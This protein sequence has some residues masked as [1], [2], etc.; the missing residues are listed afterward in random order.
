[1]K[2]ARELLISESVCSVYTKNQTGQ[3]SVFLGGWSEFRTISL[4]LGSHPYPITISFL[5]GP[6]ENKYYFCANLS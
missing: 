3:A 6:V 1:M 2:R 5:P 4:M